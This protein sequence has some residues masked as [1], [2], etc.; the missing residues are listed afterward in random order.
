MLIFDDA[1]QR[2]PLSQLTARRPCGEVMCL[3]AGGAAAGAQRCRLLSGSLDCLEEELRSWWSRWSRAS[4]PCLEPDLPC[5]W[6]LDLDL[7]P[8]LDLDLDLERWRPDFRSRRPSSPSWTPQKKRATVL[9]S[10]KSS[11]MSQRAVLTTTKRCFRQEVVNTGLLD[12]KNDRM[13]SRRKDFFCVK[14]KK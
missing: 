5:L 10:N 3:L 1:A 9:C 2:A 13:E 12:L 14:I 11:V 8:D 7:D 6:S 4:R